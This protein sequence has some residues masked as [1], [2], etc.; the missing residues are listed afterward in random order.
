MPM[1]RRFF[2]LFAV[3]LLLLTIVPGAFC[4]DIATITREA[5]GG[6]AAAEFH[7]GDAY[8]TGVGKPRD[9]TL[10]AAWWRKAAVQG[11]AEAQFNLAGAFQKGQGVPRDL[12]QSAMWMRKAAE[13]G[14]TQAEFVLSLCY[15]MGQGVPKCDKCAYF[16]MAVAVDSGGLEGPDKANAIQ[17][18]DADA[19][20][21]NPT[22]LE[23]MQERV[24]KWV[25]I[26][27]AE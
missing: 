6:D 3:A 5:A 4:Q 1:F 19:A 26:H 20:L 25:R 8:Y 12:N 10:A 13:Q 24:A 21:L 23:D 27:P 18:R 22:E 16:W 9:A 2:K 14:H 17:Y 7:L 11:Y 15:F